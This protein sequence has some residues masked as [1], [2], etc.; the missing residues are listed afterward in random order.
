MPQ[1]VDSDDTTPLLRDDASRWVQSS[2]ANKQIRNC[3]PGEVNIQQGAALALYRVGHA[4]CK[5]YEF[6]LVYCVLFFSL[7]C[8]SA[9][10]NNPKSLSLPLSF[11]LCAVMTLMMKITRVGGGQSESCTSPCSSAVWVRG[12][13]ISYS[14]F[15]LHQGLKMLTKHTAA[16]RLMHTINHQSSM[17]CLPL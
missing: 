9:D 17:V 11:Y 8:V 4:L 13:S 2:I 15:R 5:P 7:S 16:L 1:L 6:K 14:G 10:I 3:F 12:M